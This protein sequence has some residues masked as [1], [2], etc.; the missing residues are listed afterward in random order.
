MDVSKINTNCYEIP[1]KIYFFRWN[2]HFQIEIYNAKNSKPY[3]TCHV[4][5]T[6]TI[7]DLKFAIHRQIPKTPKAE[8]LSIRLEARGKQ[9]KD[10]ETLKS[11]GLQNGGKI[12]IKDLGPQIGWKTVFLAEYAGPLIVYLW[13]Y[14]RPYVFY[15]DLV[16]AQ[17]LG[18]TA[19]WVYE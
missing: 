3:G 13:V 12:F 16:N 19:Q 18:I 8:R 11:L 6:T 14:T 4:T 15:G 1:M 9:V 17:P 7:S 2:F 10:T 5:D